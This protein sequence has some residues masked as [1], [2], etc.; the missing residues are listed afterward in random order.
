[1]LINYS[2][3]PNSSWDE[4]QKEAAKK[5]G[6]DEIVDFPFLNVD[7]NWDE[8][9]IKAQ[10]EEEV[11]KILELQPAAVM[12]QGEFCLSYSIIGKLQ[13]HGITVIAACSERVVEM[14][15]QNEKVVKFQFVRFREYEKL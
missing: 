7:S 3:H 11:K 15:S 6:G 1:M 13:Q 4:K 2:N 9:K 10:A 12:C 14:K 8:N 5:W